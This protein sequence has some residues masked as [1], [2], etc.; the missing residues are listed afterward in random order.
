MLTFDIA[1]QVV[2]WQ[3]WTLQGR[4]VLDLAALPA[5]NGSGEELWLAVQ[6]AETGAVSLERMMQDATYTDGTC[7]VTPDAEGCAAVPHL[8]GLQVLVYPEGQPQK[9]VRAQVG[10]G[11]ELYLT[12]AEPGA[13]YSVGAVAEALLQTMPLEQETDF[14][15]VRQFGRAKLRLLGSDPAFSFRV[16]SSADW[17]TYDPE[18]EHLAYPFTGAV[19][20]SLVPAPATAQSLCLLCDGVFD[21][22]L[23]SLTVDTDYHGR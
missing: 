9:A 8:A 18:R 12:S 1:Q 17:E 13:R 21:F 5:E 14:N 7:T 3:H 10:A 11:G 6:H 15:T 22:R 19:R 23:L 20:L 2:A 4:R 16:A